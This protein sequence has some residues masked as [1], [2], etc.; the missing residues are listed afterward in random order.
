MRRRILFLL[1][2]FFA[3]LV[4]L[5]AALPW[6]WGRALHALAPRYGLKFGRYERVGYAR[7]ALHQVEFQRARVRVSAA[8]VEIDTPVLWLWRH[9]LGKAGEAIASTWLVEV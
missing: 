1:G 8:R 4:V 7:F 5:F 9:G 6:W 3:A 2:I